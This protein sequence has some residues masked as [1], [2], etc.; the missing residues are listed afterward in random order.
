M[1]RPVKI[2]IWV[3]VFAACAGAGAYVAAN[4]DPFPPGVEDPGDRPFPS[5]SIPTPTEA[6]RP[7]TFDVALEVESR[8]ELYVGGMCD[9]DWEATLRV[10]ADED[11]SVEATGDVGLIGE[12]QCSFPQ[13]QIQAETISVEIRGAFRGGVLSLSFTET[14]RDPHGSREL[15]G[16][17]KTLDLIRPTIELSDGGG[18][19]FVAASRGDA[20]R[21]RFLSETR[22]QVSCVRSCRDLS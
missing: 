18:S 9:T 13:A 1:S 5:S 20:D 11:G 19:D 10:V 4:T 16:F 14:G 2:V 8:H 6:P 3:V 15:G 7:V 12:A 17:A 22:F 21:G